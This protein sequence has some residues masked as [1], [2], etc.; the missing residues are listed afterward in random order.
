MTPDACV[1]SSRAD[2]QRMALRTKSLSAFPD[3]NVWKG[4]TR[5]LTS[6]Q[7]QFHGDFHHHP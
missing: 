1:I 4:R 7:F 5:L 2:D 6:W 3:E